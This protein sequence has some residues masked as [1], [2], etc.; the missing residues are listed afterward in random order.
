MQQRVA[1]QRSA[2]EQNINKSS[3]EIGKKQSTVQASSDILKGEEYNAQSKFAE[4]YE[5]E[6]GRQKF[7]SQQADSEEV[8]AKLEEMRKQ[9]DKGD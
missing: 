8:K 1:A 5:G 4:G 6:K 3:G 7:I 9:A 2:N